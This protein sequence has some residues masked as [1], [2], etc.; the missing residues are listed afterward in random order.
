MSVPLPAGTSRPG[1]WRRIG[2]VFRLRVQMVYAPSH[3][4]TVA[5]AKTLPITAAGAVPE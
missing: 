2:E 1:R 4:S 3:L 5:I